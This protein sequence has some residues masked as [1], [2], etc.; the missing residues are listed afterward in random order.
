MPRGFLVKRHDLLLNCQAQAAPTDAL[1]LTA[2]SRKHPALAAPEDFRSRSN[3]PL[4]AASKK[5]LTARVWRPALPDDADDAA[6]AAAAAAAAPVSVLGPEAEVVSSPASSRLCLEAALRW[7]QQRI[8]LLAAMSVAS[9]GGHPP[10]GTPSGGASLFHAVAPPAPPPSFPLYPPS[11]AS[12]FVHPAPIS[13][14]RAT[15]NP[16]ASGDASSSSSD[17]SDAQG[18]DLTVSKAASSSKVASSVLHSD[19]LAVPASPAAPPTP[20]TSTKKRANPTTLPSPASKKA[21]AVRKL[22]FDDELVIISSHFKSN[23][24]PDPFPILS[25]SIPDPSVG[26]VKQRQR[27][28]QRPEQRRVHGSGGLPRA[29]SRRGREPRTDSP[30]LSLPDGMED[31]AAAADDHILVFMFFFNINV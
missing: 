15:P 12:F 6:A 4:G 8:P 16:P 19:A 2:G 13:P 23:S 11:L 20:P 29:I 10:A 17:A 18:L 21:K 31:A 26:N 3:V 7:Y 25:R 24:I 14:L 22:T 9:T 27:P 28:E 30:P 1:D 5:K